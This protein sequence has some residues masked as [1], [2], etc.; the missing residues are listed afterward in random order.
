MCGI[1]ALYF[2]EWPELFKYHKSRPVNVI[3]ISILLTYCR[4]KLYVMMFDPCRITSYVLR[5]CGLYLDVLARDEM[6]FSN[7]IVPL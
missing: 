5:R 6:K 1:R 3:K 4:L 7:A 2:R